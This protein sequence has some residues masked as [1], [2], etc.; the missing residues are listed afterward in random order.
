MMETEQKDE[1]NRLFTTVNNN[2]WWLVFTVCT[3]MLLMVVYLFFMATSVYQSSTQILVNQ[4]ENNEAVIQAQNVQANLD[5]INTYNVI[6]KS[7]RILNTVKKNLKND[8]SE[9]ELAKAIQVS[10]AA[11]SQVIE[12]KVESTD[13]Q[14]AVAIANET[15]KVFKKEIFQIMKVNNVDILSI[16]SNKKKFKPV[17]PRKIIILT[18]SF[19]LGVSIGII[20]ILIRLLLDRTLKNKEEISQVFKLQLL[21]SIYEITESRRNNRKVNHEKKKIKKKRK[22]RIQVNN[23]NG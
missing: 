7:P 6:I 12:I 21:G 16:A 11:N 10:N 1:F 8:Y 23:D 15:A 3:S 9:D 13:P 19:F 22:K 5:L 17:K 2:K 20:I 4:K 18:L 14:E